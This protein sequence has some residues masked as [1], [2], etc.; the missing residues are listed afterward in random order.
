M[1]KAIGRKL[2]DRAQILERTQVILQHTSSI[3]SHYRVTAEV[4]YDSFQDFLTIT[5]ATKTGASELHLHL[6]DIAELLK[7]AG[8]G[9]R[10]IL[11]R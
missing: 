4:S 11:I 9:V 7:H 3:L 5:A 8:C 6:T 2:N 1:F 10:R